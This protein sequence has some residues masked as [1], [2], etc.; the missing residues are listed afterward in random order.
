M[1]R[2]PLK[3]TAL[4][5]KPADKYKCKCL[6]GERA[7][8]YYGD[9][10]F[11]SQDCA[12]NFTVKEAAKRKKKEEVEYKRETTKMRVSARK[13]TEWYQLLQTEVNQ[14]VRDRDSDKLCC[15]CN[16]ATVTSKYDAGHF[17][18]VST[19]KDVRFNLMNIHKQCAQCNNQYGGQRDIY[20]IFMVGK[21]GADRVE[22]LRGPQK[23]LKEQFPTTQDIAEEIKRYRK[24]NKDFKRAQ[25]N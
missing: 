17:L 5:V 1:K 12:F 10:P 3:R 13:R 11:F 25:N 22:F 2:T 16:T 24:M 7:T 21:Y 23:T 6:C 19:H 4:K 15:T 18:A 9:F 14:H 20:Q 8:Q